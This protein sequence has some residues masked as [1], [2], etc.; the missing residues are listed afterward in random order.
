MIVKK[1]KSKLN[2]ISLFCGC[3]GL[4]IGFT[5][6]GFE[7]LSA[8]DI[9]PIAIE[10]N[11]QNLNSPAIVLDIF[12]DV[13]STELNKSAFSGDGIPLVDAVTLGGL[14]Q[15]KSEARRLIQ[16][17]GICVNNIR[18]TDVKSTITLDRAIEGRA[19]VLRKGPKDYRLLKVT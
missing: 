17:G 10:V 16:G 7:C 18:I 15:S 6:A 11:R 3:G 1:R 9:D 2:Y 8:F 4:D 13:P 5:S 12:N 19:L 14:A